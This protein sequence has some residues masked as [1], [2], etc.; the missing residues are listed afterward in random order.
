MREI[1]FRPGDD[2]VDDLNGRK[3]LLALGFPEKHVARFVAWRNQYKRGFLPPEDIADKQIFLD[4][5]KWLVE[6]KRLDEFPSELPPI[7]HQELYSFSLPPLERVKDFVQSEEAKGNSD[8]FGEFKIHE[9]NVDAK[10]VLE[11][12][13]RILDKPQEEKTIENPETENI[14]T[15][16]KKLYKELTEKV[17]S[18]PNAKIEYWRV[19]WNWAN[20][21]ERR[22]VTLEPEKYKLKIAASLEKEGAL[23]LIAYTKPNPTRPGGEGSYFGAMILSTGVTLVEKGIINYSFKPLLNYMIYAKNI[24]IKKSEISSTLS[25][26]IEIIHSF[27][28]HYLNGNPSVKSDIFAWDL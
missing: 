17:E 22:T 27:I 10:D 3:N 9:R 18:D 23:N 14:V 28:Q 20:I 13:K 11:E 19:P 26:D 4:F 7:I 1:E 8:P 2:S 21:Q 12:A 6:N 24:R 15:K 16:F 25:D 5:A